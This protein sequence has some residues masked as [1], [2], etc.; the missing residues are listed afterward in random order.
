[1]T[2]QI[3]ESNF[4]P[5]TLETLSGNPR[6][7]QVVVTNSSYVPGGTTV[8]STGG[9]VQITGTNFLT[10]VQ[11]LFDDTLASAVTRVSSTQLNVQTPI[12]AVGTY[13]VYV[14]NTDG[15]TGLVTAAVTVA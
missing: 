11:V 6:I 3:S 4:Q 5:S 8:P 12:L 15:G 13:F 7:T 14:V 9:Y 10:G 2:T 1:M